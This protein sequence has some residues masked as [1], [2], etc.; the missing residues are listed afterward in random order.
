MSSIHVNGTPHE[1]GD[2]I[3]PQMPLLWLLRDTLGLVGTKYGCGIGACSACTVLLNGAPMQSCMLTVQAAIGQRITTIEGLAAADG[4][5]S[6][7]QQ[8]WVDEDVAQC[9]YCQAG[10]IVRATALLATNPA[11][12]DADIDTQMS[13][14]LCR[15]GTYTRVR[16]AIHTAAGRMRSVADNAADG[17][18]A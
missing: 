9:G 14:N 3:D 10:Q 5:L 11:P 15:C 16:R 17:G 2:E 12:S 4:T 8:A 13:A 7:V 18:A 1:L 6:A